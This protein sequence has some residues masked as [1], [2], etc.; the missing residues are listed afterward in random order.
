[1]NSNLLFSPNTKHFLGILILVLIIAAGCGSENT[2]PVLTSAAPHDTNQLVNTQ[3]IPTMTAEQIPGSP[4]PDEV[5]QNP[6]SITPE[7][8]QYQITAELD[9]N[10]HL[11]FVR[12]T[13][14]VPH[15]AKIP[16]DEIVLVAPPNAWANVFS[17][18]SINRESDQSVEDY[19]L[20]GIRL[21][22]PLE[23]PWLPGESIEL[24]IQYNLALPVQNAREGYG[25]SPFGYTALQTNLVDWYPMVPP[26]QEDQGWVIHDPWIFGEY[27][28]YPVADFTVSLDISGPDLVV[29]ASS[30]AIQDENKRNYLLDGGRNF[31][32]SVSPDY[33]VMEQDLNGVKVYGYVF[34]PYLV[35]GA[36]AFKTTVESLGLFSEIFGPYN[37]SSLSMVQA[38]FNH[39]MEYE[40]LYFQSRGFFDTYNGSEQSYLVT[41]AAHETAHQ[42]WYGQVAN[43]QAL[44][45]WLD[46]SF[47]TFSELIYYETLYPESVNWWWATRV[48][49]YEPYGVINRSIYDYSEFNDQYLAYR[50]ATYLQG[51][52]FLD[53]LRR[54]LGVDI[55][56]EFIREYAGKFSNQIST[57]GDFLSLLNSYYDLDSATW[58]SD[59]LKE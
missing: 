7:I 4:T 52:K 50:N 8:I 26:Y 39:G 35:P 15:P 44:E 9:Y 27:L 28:V 5:E 43:D 21:I 59:Y 2:I 55:F 36:A 41:I 17:I 32:F 40:G 3:S 30:I 34:P 6:V 13:I 20:N 16:L 1:M 18:E 24:A 53:N 47:C 31:V 14:L 11:V 48:N 19:I 33:Q 46:E 10:N 58:L 23:Q 42:W 51:A 25:P 54:E 56:N 29:A 22:I 12:E 37:Q 57:G 38:D 45:P 49:Y